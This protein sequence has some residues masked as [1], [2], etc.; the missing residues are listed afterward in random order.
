M[1]TYEIT[2]KGKTFRIKTPA[3][4]VLTILCAILAILSVAGL[5]LLFYLLY[6]HYAETGESGKATL[7]LIALGIYGAFLV[8]EIILYPVTRA[9]KLMSKDRQKQ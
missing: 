1:K 5:P 9:Y 3:V 7:W 8:G 4:I 6:S 2:I